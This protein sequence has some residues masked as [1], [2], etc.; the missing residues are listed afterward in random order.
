[1]NPAVANTFYSARGLA[2][3]VDFAMLKISVAAIPADWDCVYAD[4]ELLAI[5]GCATHI[6]GKQ[7]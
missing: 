1:M 2:L 4:R 5:F 3:N 7:I 6:C